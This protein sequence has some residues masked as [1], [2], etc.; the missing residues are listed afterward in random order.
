MIENLEAQIR[1]R[2]AVDFILKSATYEDVPF[3]Q[4]PE[5]VES[6]S[7]SICGTSTAAVGDEADDE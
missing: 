5:D 7:L 3:P 4:P 1:E 6:V 2:K